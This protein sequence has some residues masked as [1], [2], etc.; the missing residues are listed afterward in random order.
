LFYY[1]SCERVQIRHYP[2]IFELCM[3]KIRTIGKMRYSLAKPYL[4]NDNAF[5]DISLG[6]FF[7]AI[8]VKFRQGYTVNLPIFFKLY[9]I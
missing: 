7:I 4:K 3:G 5:L 1:D 2:L 9:K 6:F 8:L